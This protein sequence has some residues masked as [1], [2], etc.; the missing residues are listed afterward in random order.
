MNAPSL[1]FE[2]KPCTPQ[3]FIDAARAFQGLRYATTGTYSNPP[4][5]GPG[6]TGRT[7]CAGILL[8][9][10]RRLGLWPETFPVDL[11]W[12]VFKR[13]R[14]DLLV[15]IL[16]RNFH[17]VKRDELRPGDVMFLRYA[18]AAGNDP[19]GRHLAIYTSDSPE[20][21]IHCWCDFGGSGRVFEQHI[22]AID[23]SCVRRVWRMNN[24][25]FSS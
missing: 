7:D 2:P 19:G 12:P 13:E 25:G 3:E 9:A 15:E 11:A 21:M 17:Q 16:T 22:R 1:Q 5:G 20:R 6:A 8:L 4:L 23:W 18:N 10:V 14:P 24:F